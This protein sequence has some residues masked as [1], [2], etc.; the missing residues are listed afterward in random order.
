M[1]IIGETV[2]WRYHVVSAAPTSGGTLTL[3]T[4]TLS[5][6]TRRTQHPKHFR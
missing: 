3:S 1:W 4:L 6:L 2:T 5:T